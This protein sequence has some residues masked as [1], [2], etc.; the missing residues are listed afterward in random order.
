MDAAFCRTPIPA[1][2]SGRHYFVRK[3]FDLNTLV[4]KCDQ[5]KEQTLLPYYFL[6]NGQAIGCDKNKMSVQ[7]ILFYFQS[8]N[9]VIRLNT[10]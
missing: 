2:R 8:I 9:K 7:I 4:T 10:F 6:N 5:K 1:Y 3:P